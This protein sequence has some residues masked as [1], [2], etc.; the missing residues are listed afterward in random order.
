MSDKS[1]Q[2][3][4][5]VKVAHVMSNLQT[6]LDFKKSKVMVTKSHNAHTIN[7]HVSHKRTKFGGV[8]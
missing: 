6:S 3:K 7:T 4:T 8:P 2:P 5:D 1:S